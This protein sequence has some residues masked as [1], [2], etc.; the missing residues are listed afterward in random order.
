MKKL[1]LSIILLASIGGVSAQELKKSTFGVHAGA[2]FS[3]ISMKAEGV[4]VNMTSR[5]GFQ[6]GVSYE[7]LLSKKSPLYFETGLYF[8]QKGA[9]T[10]TTRVQIKINQSQII[11]PALI[12]Y[13]FNL[14]YGI[15]F[16]PFAGLYYSIGVGG[17]STMSMNN[18]VVNSGGQVDS[19]GT[20]SDLNRSELGMRIGAGFNFNKVA[21]KVG[22][23]RG[24][25]N[26]VTDTD[27]LMDASL[28]SSAITVSVGYRF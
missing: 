3:N 21:L 13:Q 24:F 26:I 12:N 1:L 16:V 17:E 14:G 19:Y 25:T 27:D 7:A 15:A 2:I 8:T 11:L 6:A 18:G 9:K 23:E 4:S 20:D 28:K 22:Y 5:V 10:N